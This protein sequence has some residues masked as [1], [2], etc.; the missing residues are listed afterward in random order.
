M[1]KIQFVRA[2]LFCF[3]VFRLSKE[4]QRR[5]Q[6]L[7]G[8]IY[9]ILPAHQLFHSGE[10]PQNAYLCCAI[11]AILDFVLI[12]FLL[13]KITYRA[14]DPSLPKPTGAKQVPLNIGVVFCGRQAPGGHNV[15]AAVYDGVKE[16]SSGG[17]VYGFIGGS[18]T[19][20][21]D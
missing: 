18:F 20:G 10:T 21:S 17:K 14:A 11:N 1:L 5:R 6:S 7:S 15:V 13:F 9:P 12:F 16:I 8:N 2:F 3:C 19:V 4:K